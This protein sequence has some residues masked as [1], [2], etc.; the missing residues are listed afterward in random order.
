MGMRLRRLVVGPGRKEDIGL[1]AGYRLV[2]SLFLF[3]SGED[4]GDS[5]NNLL[6]W[7]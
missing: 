1:R 4:V 5:R 2:S 7:E 3:T 6:L